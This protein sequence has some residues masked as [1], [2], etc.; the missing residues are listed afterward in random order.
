VAVTY[1]T[2][3]STTTYAAAAP[4]WYTDAALTQ[5]VV[6]TPTFA[7]VTVIPPASNLPLTGGVGFGAW[8]LPILIGVVLIT[9]AGIAI[10]KG[11]GALMSR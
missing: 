1:T 8:G 7:N 9:G 10:R 2:S 4:V 11:K 6:G 5:A 3:G